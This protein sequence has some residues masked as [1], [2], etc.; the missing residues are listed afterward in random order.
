MQ[1]AGAVDERACEEGFDRQI[2]LR[3][4]HQDRADAYIFEAF[5]S[6]LSHPACQHNVA[7]L[8]RGEH[9]AVLLPSVAAVPPALDL[10]PLVVALK[11]LAL[12]IAVAGFCPQLPSLH[13]AL[14]YGKDGKLDRPPKVGADSSSIVFN[15][16]KFH[17]FDYT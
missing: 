10:M 4:I 1:P 8:D 13:L 7:I 6:T 14:L 16:G 9:P 17:T 11:P 15:R 3:D 2:G 12:K 5:A